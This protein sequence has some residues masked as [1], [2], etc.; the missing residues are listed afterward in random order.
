[1]PSIKPNNYVKTANDL[2]STESLII[3]NPNNL[4]MI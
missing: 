3:M 1:M 2:R 4:K